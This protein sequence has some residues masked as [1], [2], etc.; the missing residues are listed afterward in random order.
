MWKLNPTELLQFKGDGPRFSNFVDR[1]IRAEAA[2]SGLIQSEIRTQLRVHIPDG[3]VDTEVR[4]AFPHDR[5]GW[6]GIPTCWQFKAQEAKDIGPADL[7]KEINKPYV[8]ELVKKGYGYRICLLGDLTPEKETEWEGVLNDEAKNINSAAA[9][10]RVVHGGDLLQWAERVPAIVLWIRGGSFAVFHLDAWRQSC[11]A[12]TPKYVANPEWE[13]FRQQIRQQGSFCEPCVGGNACLTVGGAAGVGKTRLVFESLN[14]LGEAPGLVVYAAD[15]QEAVRVAASI[16]NSGMQRAV[17]VADECTPPTRQL[18]NDTIC[19]GHTDR[20]RVLYL[21][22][23]GERLISKASQIWLSPDALKN[24]AEILEE[25]YPDVPNDRRHQYSNLSRGFVRLAADMCFHDDELKTGNLAG[26]L[27]SVQQYVHHRLVGNHL[28]LIS[29]L[30]LF[31]KVGFSHEV[32]NEIEEIAALSGFAVQQFKDAVRQVRESPG[33][34][35]QAGRYWYV[36]PDI[37]ARVLFAEGWARWVTDNPAKFLQRLPEHLQRQLIDRASTLGEQEVR[38]QVADFFRRWSDELTVKDLQSTEVVTLLQSIVEAAPDKYLPRLRAL[39]ESG[40]QEDIVQITGEGR[41][42]SWGPRRTLVWLLERLVSFPELFVDCEACLFRLA[43]YESEPRIGNNATRIWQGL[44]NVYLSGTATPFVDRAKVVRDR[45]FSSDE[46]EVRL[47]FSGLSR[48]LSHSTGHVLGPEVV[49]GRLRPSDWQP[50]TYGEERRCYREAI[51]ICGEHISG[52]SPIQ[53]QFAID[54]LLNGANHLLHRGLCDELAQSLAVSQLS[55]TEV[56]KLLRTIDEFIHLQEETGKEEAN[57]KMRSYVKRVRAWAASLR[58]SDFDGVLRSV[59]SRDPW[60]DRF[61]NDRGAET[62]ELSQLVAQIL[63]KP[64]LLAAHLDWLAS[65]EAASAERLGF[66]LGRVDEQFSCGRM[67]WNHAVAKGL[68][69][70]L[71]GYIRGFVAGQKQPSREMISLLE[72]LEASHP[73]IAVDILSYGGDAFDA[74]NRVVRLV[75]ANLV[76]VRALSVF[77]IG[78]GQRG[79][80]ILELRQ[81]LGHFS[82]IDSAS[83]A[84]TLRAGVRFLATVSD[85]WAHWGND[86]RVL[87]DETVRTNAWRIE[88]NA[89]PFVAGHLVYDWKQIAAELAKYD[90]R[91]ACQLLGRALVIDN[92]DLERQAQEQL[93]HLAPSKPNEVMESLGR[94][95]LDA[96]EG[97]RLQVNVLHDLVAKIAPSSVMKW[98]ERH[99]LEG[100]RKL[101]RHLPPPFVD[102]NGE[103]I[104]PEVLETVFERFD[105]EKVFDNFLAGSHS[106]EMWSG[107]A[108]DR[109]RDEAENARKF[110]NHPNRWIREWANHEIASRTSMAEWEDRE[111]AERFLPS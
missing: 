96:K 88:E 71:R 11:H 15:E 111:H 68:A 66:A 37:V 86:G 63:A 89:L 2:T 53:R 38:A 45:T 57:D 65:P 20:I 77:S 94:A 99:G 3:G 44:F 107:N 103:H 98:L 72:H 12:S 55:E 36:T 67:I 25:N 24:T 40:S 34:V 46:Q 50:E 5:T 17:L 31:N 51:A 54:T 39:L 76:P 92:F 102:D 101:A 70:L 91:R 82:S 16:V 81:L 26:L 110:L 69:P 8:Q 7:R 95:L 21:D 42:S 90:G 19:R 104:V 78:T 4:A 49:G 97:W 105:D 58:P 28:P 1:M 52:G 74:L 30:A 48:T 61:R 85:R 27:G 32:E 29:F 80:N 10:A 60:D 9:L 43:L 6:F 41:G 108:A 87:D 22:N 33:F 106:G 64:D 13:P 14:E 100:A 56:R 79:L 83:D 84:D 47:A 62:D 35:V 18:L 23:T 109:F 75:E 59:L 73:M 93:E